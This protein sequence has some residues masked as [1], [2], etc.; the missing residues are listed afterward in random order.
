M[1]DDQYEKQMKVLGRPKQVAKQV[2]CRA[3]G[4]P[5]ESLKS[6]STIAPANTR[7]SL[8]AGT[9]LGQHRR[10]WPN[11]VPTLSKCFVFAGHVRLYASPVARTAQAKYGDA[12]KR[13]PH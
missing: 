3:T 11:V 7:R 5:G 6:W 9:T 13:R 8:N 2:T 10:R 4:I 1:T 12:L